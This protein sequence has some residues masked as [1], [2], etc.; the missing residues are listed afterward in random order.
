MK[1]A[2]WLLT[3]IAFFFPLSL[4]SDD[5]SYYDRSFVRVTFVKG[6]A[7]VHRVEDLGSEEAIVNLAL[8]EGDKLEGR[9]GRVEIH[10][11][12]KNYLRLDRQTVVEFSN[13][14]RS[15]DDRT[16]LHLLG[17]K[18]YL[19]IAL[20]DEEKTYEIHTPDAS[21]YVLEEGL[22]RFEMRPSGETELAVLEGSIE[23]AGEGGSQL[24][25]SRQSLVASNGHLGSQTVLALH[26]DDF[27]YWNDDRDS[28]HSQ[29]VSKRYL[30]SELDDYEYEL[31][32]NGSWVYERPYGYVWV[33]QVYYSDWRPYYYG[34]WLWYPI[35]GW[36][37]TSY[38][39]WGWCTYHYGRW[40]WRMGLG[41]Y[42]IPHHAWGP[43]WVHWYWGH[44]YWG[45][46][47][48][49]WYNYPGVIINNYFYDRYH[50]SRY[51]AGSRALTVV[52]KN[53]LQDRN[54]SHV[55]LSQVEASRLGEI[56]LQKRQPD[57]KPTISRTGLRNA[58]P[59]RGLQQPQIRPSSL[60]K[61]QSLRSVD[62]PSRVEKG[63]I[64]SRDQ[65]VSSR[66]RS[67]TSERV[68]TRSLTR[69]E[70]TP[71][72]FPSSV[73][74]RSVREPAETSSSSPR[75]IRSDSGSVNRSSASSSRSEV[76]TYSSSPR[77]S[78]G[79]SRPSV[80]RKASPRVYS[81]SSNISR[82]GTSYGLRSSRGSEPR[83]SN[84]GQSRLKEWS[85]RSAGK[86]SGFSSNTP[87]RSFSSPSLSRRE[88]NPG[89]RSFSSP[90]SRSAFSAPRSSSSSSSA[91][92]SSAPRSS[93]SSRGSS[94]GSVRKKG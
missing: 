57:I 2:A 52:H 89:L 10:F 81:P 64:V 5:N 30:P 36:T 31:A 41:W 46:A 16:R 53:S 86:S 66:S 61:S 43:A 82:Y 22:Y 94:G 91:S 3:A 37:W 79:S 35:S 18:I 93:S 44:D 1:K 28:L 9:E 74:E 17:G 8:V 15:G 73:R 88:S 11:G 19:R 75:K 80:E 60:G 20:L 4:F 59:V 27:D 84:F 24:V 58:E 14:P 6:D 70:N 63:S 33:P 39:P 51:P 85:S 23:A 49:S 56:E 40:G 38:E 7:I 72:S 13:L 26:R 54:I 71:R 77:V 62:S 69:N 90:S 67:E 55:A 48:L 25:G 34:R 78:S 50:Y 68:P 45:W 32:D 12:R 65:G 76:R 21:F 29:Y 87:S 42:W 92:R 47:P 83:A